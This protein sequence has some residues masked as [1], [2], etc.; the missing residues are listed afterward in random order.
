[1]CL[2]AVVLLLPVLVVCALPLPHATTAMPA[3][4][5]IVPASAAIAATTTAAGHSVRWLLLLH[6][7][8][9][10]CSVEIADQRN[11]HYCCCVLRWCVV[12]LQPPLW[13]V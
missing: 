12:L 4:T 5:C 2:A 8:S 10:T 7:A 9:S 6:N 3:A 1:M 11:A 13:H